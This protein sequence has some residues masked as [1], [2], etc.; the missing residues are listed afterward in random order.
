MRAANGARRRR[1]RQSANDEQYI[2]G[3]EAGQ[4]WRE[5]AI[6]ASGIVDRRGFRTSTKEERG[7]SADMSRP[8]L[9]R[10]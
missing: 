3:R 6:P 5:E 8:A 7:A 4:S 2:E 10:R 1:T 9:Q